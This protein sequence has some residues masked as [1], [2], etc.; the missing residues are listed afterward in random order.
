M[1]RF[2]YSCFLLGTWLTIIV[3]LL[4]CCTP[5][6]SPQTFFLMPVLALAFPYLACC[7]V[8][9]ILCWFFLKKR[10]SLYLLIVLFCGFTNLTRTFAVSIPTSGNRDTASIR[11]LSWNTQN[12]GYAGKEFDTAGNLR[13]RMLAYVQ[14]VNADIIC[15]QEMT[16]YTGEQYLSNVEAM[17]S[18]GYRYHFISNELVRVY[19]PVTQ[20][21]G[22]LIFSRYPI[23]D[24][25]SALTGDSSYPE[26]VLYADIMAKEKMVRVATCHFKSINIFGKGE[27]PHN[28]TPFHGDS[29]FMYVSTPAKKMVA[30]GREHSLQ[31]MLVKDFISNSPYPLVFT[32]D[33]NSV[34]TSH[35]YATLA[36]GMQDAFIK[37]GNGLGGSL[38]SLPKTLRIDYLFADKHFDIL[39]YHQDRVALSDHFP[40]YTDV[41]LKR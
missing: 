1:K 2:L 5:V 30:F 28:R 29:A 38:D 13:R 33:M 21:L 12:F 24:T 37:R 8:V 17:R 32:C 25:A 23:V 18:L 4:S 9:L 39:D 31:A 26:K 10:Y 22:S 27:D 36:T 34:P 7:V 16:E 20:R 40:H 3:Y 6:I 14:R 11:V 19:P 35:A 41:R 15:L